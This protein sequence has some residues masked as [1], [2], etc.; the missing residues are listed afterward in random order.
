MK[1]KPCKHYFVPDVVR[2]VAVC[3]YCG[4]EISLDELYNFIYAPWKGRGDKK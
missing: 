3:V 2:N 4:K 1:K